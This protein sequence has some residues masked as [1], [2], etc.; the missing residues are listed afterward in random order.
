MDAAW[1]VKVA[2]YETASNGPAA[3]SGSLICKLSSNAA[4]AVLATSQPTS[5]ARICNPQQNRD[6]LTC[7]PKNLLLAQARPSGPNLLA[8]RGATQEMR[9]PRTAGHLRAN[10][11]GKL[12]PARPTT[13]WLAFACASAFSGHG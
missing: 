11:S 8:C 2:V 3:R 12:F 4:C 10:R 7:E 6:R 1:F 5:N 13:L 9:L